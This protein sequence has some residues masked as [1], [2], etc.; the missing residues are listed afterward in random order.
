M[1]PAAR[2]AATIE[3]LDA[4]DATPRPADGTLAAFFR[5]RRYM[6]A[7]DRSAVAERVYAILRHRARLAW[8]LAR[9]GGAEAE[10][11]GR[12]LV[13]GDTVLREGTGLK[14]LGR[15]FDGGQYAPAALTDDE[16]ALAR[17]LAGQALDDPAMPEP[18]RTEC[19]DWA[20]APLHAAFGDRFG[21]ELLALLQPAPLDLRVQEGRQ[22]REAVIARLARDGIEAAPTP[23][24]PLGIRVTGRPPLAG[25]PL[26]RSGVIEVQD[27]GSQLVALLADAR[28]GQQV[29]DFCAGAGGK[30]LAMAARMQGKGRVVA[31]EIA[32]GRL[33]RAKERIKRA[34]VDNIEPRRLEHERDKWVRRQKGKFDRVLI[35]APCSGCGAWRR[36]PDARWRPTDLPAL[37]DLQARILASAAR[38]TKPGGRLVYATCSL[39]PEENR[40]QIDHFLSETDAFAVVPVAD[41]WPAA[42]GTPPP[43]GDGP[44]LQLTPARHHTDGFFVAVLERTAAP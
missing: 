24:S 14:D 36:N 4:I 26:F 31:C 38:L 16:R 25:H 43:A 20:A 6:G 22:S 37:A 27:E 5:Q 2:L 13:L 10:P 44:F 11:D 29:A 18:V 41:V 17:A 23:L 39:L 30:A 7:K 33:I 3:A 9:A 42:V 35:D 15:L 1:T 34:G 32:E 21:D 40:Q 28:P 12:L 19:P 8:A